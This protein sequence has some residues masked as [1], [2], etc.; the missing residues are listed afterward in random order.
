MENLNLPT[1]SVKT[2]IINDK[3][4]IF[5]E[6]RNKFVIL[7]PE[8]WVRQHFIHYLV[9]EKQFPKSLLSIEKLMILNKNKFRADIV[10]YNSEA[11][12]ILIVEC[13]A[14]NVK[15]EQS[16]F[17]QIATYN[18]LHKVEY[19]VVT[20]GLNHYCCKINFDDNSYEFIKEIP[21]SGEL[22]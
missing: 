9:N 15:I 12:P 2:K 4:Y 5:D 8:E 1:Y 21:N 7:Q 13:K 14:P 11:K 22:R 6:I 3:T 20:N 17:E 16:V 18:I 19:L 10:A